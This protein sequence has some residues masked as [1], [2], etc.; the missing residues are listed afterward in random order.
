MTFEFCLGKLLHNLSHSAAQLFQNKVK[1]KEFLVLYHII[2][3]C[4]TP[5][6]LHVM[7]I[8]C[9]VKV[10]NERIFLKYGKNHCGSKRLL[11]FFYNFY[12]LSRRGVVLNFKFGP[13]SLYACNRSETAVRYIRGIHANFE[14][15][16]IKCQ[17]F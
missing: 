12:N 9:Y 15:R 14:V 13:I 8:K 3:N 10:G 17:P 2:E 6:A 16:S 5:R 1:C 4:P 7:D 11:I